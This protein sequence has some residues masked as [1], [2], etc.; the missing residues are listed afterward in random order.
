MTPGNTECSDGAR[1]LADRMKSHP[2]EFDPG[3]R[4]SAVVHTLRHQEGGTVQLTPRDRAFLE[5]ALEELD[6]YQLT[7]DVAQA[8]L[9]DGEGRF[10]VYKSPISTSPYDSYERA[11]HRAHRRYGN[12]FGDT[13]QLALQNAKL[14][15]LEKDITQ[16]SKG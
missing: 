10:K 2:Q 5:R 4:F 11:K 8:I 9:G 12:P 7:T 13:D 6:E 16:W 1:M 15:Q 3:G 14:A